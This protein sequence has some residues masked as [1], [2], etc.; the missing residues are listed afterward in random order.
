[1]IFYFTNHIPII[2]KHQPPSHTFHSLRFQSCYL[3]DYVSLGDNRIRFSRYLKSLSVLEKRV[4]LSLSTRRVGSFLRLFCDL[5]CDR[6]HPAD[7]GNVSQSVRF[8]SS[9][10]NQLA[11]SIIQSSQIQERRMSEEGKFE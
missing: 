4:L 5:S 10:V 2:S 8:V 7:N 6:Q 1:M 11:I 3:G 9:F